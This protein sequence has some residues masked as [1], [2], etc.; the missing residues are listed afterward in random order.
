MSPEDY[1]MMADSPVKHDTSHIEPYEDYCRWV[2][3]GN[4]EV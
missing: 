1:D 3:K 2:I 4:D